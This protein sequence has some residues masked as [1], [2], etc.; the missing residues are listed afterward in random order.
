M[1]LVPALP[2][3]Y[4]T[5]DKA[6]LHFRRYDRD[7]LQRLVDRGRVRRARDLTY[8]NLF[9]GSAGG[10]T[11]GVLKRNHLPGGQSRLFDLFVPIL[12]RIEPESPSKGLSVIAIAL[13]PATATA[14]GAAQLSSAS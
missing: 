1:L 4:G 3:L 14:S 5:L 7:G 13:K 10:S 2:A 9:G 6:L 12:R 8:R 11:G